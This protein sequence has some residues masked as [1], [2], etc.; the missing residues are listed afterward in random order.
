MRS[1]ARR[2]TPSRRCP[3]LTDRIPATRRSNWRCVCAVTST[4]SVT[5]SHEGANALLRRLRRHHLLVA[6][7]RAVAEANPPEPGDLDRGLLDERREMGAAPPASA[8]R[9]ARAFAPSARRPP[10]AASGPRCRARRASAAR[11]RPR[12]RASPPA[13]APRSGR[14]RTRRGP[15]RAGRAPTGRPRARP[16]SRGRRRRRRPSSAFTSDAVG[17]AT[18]RRRKGV[19]WVP[20]WV[21]VLLIILLVLV[22]FGGVGYGRR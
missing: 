20:T 9:G 17:L 22:L 7:R 4:A 16:C 3:T 14:R 2:R 11:G 12:A 6:P 21:W 18:S 1:R 15:G 8:A 19:S 13:P 10:R 5:P